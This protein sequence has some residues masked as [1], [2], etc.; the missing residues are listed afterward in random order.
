MI[1]PENVKIMTVADRVTSS[2]KKMAA[3]KLYEQQ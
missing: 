2:F 3:A 1:K